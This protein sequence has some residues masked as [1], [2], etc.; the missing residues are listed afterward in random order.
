MQGDWCRAGR[1]R[2]TVAR[3]FVP[4][5]IIHQALAFCCGG[6]PSCH[7]SIPH[8]MLPVP[9]LLHLVLP[10]AGGGGGAHLVPPSTHLSSPSLLFVSPPSLRA[11]LAACE[12]RIAA[13]RCALLAAVARVHADFLTLTHCNAR[14]THTHAHTQVW[15]DVRGALMR[16]HTQACAHTRP[17]THMHMMHTRIPRRTQTRRP[18]RTC[19]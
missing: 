15:L 9:S 19:T 18:T 16:T 10:I 17:H 7:P 4:Q 3:V 12:R 13:F 6:S 2:V 11:R 1:C 5:L 14:G 8:T